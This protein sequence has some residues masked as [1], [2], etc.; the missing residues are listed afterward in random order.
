MQTQTRPASAGRPSDHHTCRPAKATASN[1]RPAVTAR[2]AEMGDGHE[3]GGTVEFI[4]EIVPG[5]Y[6]PSDGAD[7]A[8]G[9]A[10]GPRRATAALASAESASTTT[11]SDN[12]WASEVNARKAVATVTP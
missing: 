5:D 2:S 6:L 4:C 12:R 3:P 8:A 1:V 11:S 7:D 10:A 9:D